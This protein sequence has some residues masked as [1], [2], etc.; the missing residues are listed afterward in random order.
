MSDGSAAGGQYL[1][2]NN[3][4][5]SQ[6]DAPLAAPGDYF[7]ASFSAPAGTYHVWLRLRAASNSKYN[8][9]VWVQFSNATLDVNQRVQLFNSN[10]DL[11]G[12]FSTIQAAINAG[13]DPL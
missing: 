13:A 10:G 4:G 12:T 11:I 7:E 6:T 8:E 3:N 2:S 9:S 5:W 1:A